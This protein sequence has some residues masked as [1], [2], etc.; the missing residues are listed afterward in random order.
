MGSYIVRINVVHREPRFFTGT[1]KNFNANNRK[2]YGKHILIKKLK[3][4]RMVHREPQ[5]LEEIY[6]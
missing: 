1:I 2:V 6:K 5:I 3:K 4:L